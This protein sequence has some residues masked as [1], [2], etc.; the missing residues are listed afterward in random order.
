MLQGLRLSSCLSFNAASSGSS[1][2]VL[3]VVSLKYGGIFLAAGMKNGIKY[4]QDQSSIMLLLDHSL[5][6]NAVVLK[7][8]LKRIMFKFSSIMYL[9]VPKEAKTGLFRRRKSRT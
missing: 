6:H 9:T 7:V 1:S 4:N 8:T 3:T 2:V 5:R